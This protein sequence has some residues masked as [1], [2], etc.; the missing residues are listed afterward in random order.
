MS[1]IKCIKFKNH[2]VLGDLYLDFTDN[3]GNVAD[4]VIFAGENG[5]GKSTVLNEL[6]SLTAG[7]MRSEALIEL[8]VEQK[9]VLL[10]CKLNGGMHYAFI[11]GNRHI[12]GSS[13]FMRQYGLKGIF[14]DVDINF[15][16]RDL[17]SV[18]SLDVDMGRT[19]HRSTNDL[20]QQINQLIIDIQALDD[21]AVSKAFRDAKENGR[22]TNT[23]S[24]S[25]RMPRFTNAFNYIF[26]DL[27]YDRVKNIG[28]HKAIIFK[29]NGV[30]VPVSNLSSG[31]KQIVYRGSFLL[32]D[33][34]AM[35]GAYVFIDEPEISMHPA[36][37]EKIMEYYKRIFTDEKGV[38][39]SQIFAVTHSPFI[40]HNSNRQNDKV[41]ILA[42]DASGKI[43]VS[44]KPSYYKCNSIEA[45]EDAFSVTPFSKLISDEKGSVFLEGRT[46]ERYFNK[47]VEVF[48]YTDLPFDFK[49]IGYIDENDQEK[50]TGFSALNS[51]LS[52]LTARN[53]QT[54]NACLFDCDTNKPR[55]IKNNTLS[56]AIPKYENSK[57]IKKGIENALVLDDIELDDFY[58]TKIT[59]GDYGESKTISTFDKMRFC[60]YICND[61][62]HE[63]L[64]V[65][66]S[67]L[68]I[69]IDELI[70]FFNGEENEAGN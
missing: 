43:V 68:K 3:N 46:D 55:C 47:A 2:P 60:K 10:D 61:V 33:I 7:R 50:N 52:F 28:G 36:W 25:E 58:S 15:N 6:Y 56:V 45:V 9:T 14:S 57:G 4:T 69:Q 70:E 64:K 44:D 16:S 20:P 12:T 37:Q 29:K 59:Q 24:V 11:N 42:R 38:Q 17:S 21:A 51:A 65:I 67:N 34:N 30:D 66:F 63:N 62:D 53:Y 23:L 41:I 54:K 13:D 32:K 27:K 49:W 8:E 22:D 40:I 1:R 31:E 19:S 18:T 39:T 48:G 5:T 35:N 26:S